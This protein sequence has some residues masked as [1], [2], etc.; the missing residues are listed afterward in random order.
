[1]RS[2]KIHL[3]VLFTLALTSASPCFS[4]TMSNTSTVI[5]LTSTCINDHLS[6]GTYTL[7]LYYIDPDNGPIHQTASVSVVVVHSTTVTVTLPSPTLPTPATTGY[8]SLPDADFGSL[9]F[10]GAGGGLMGFYHEPPD[11][12]LTFNCTPLGIT[13]NLRGQLPQPI[14]KSFGFDLMMLLK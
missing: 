4:Q 13:G 8:W 3:L 10:T 2:L 12:D 9:T 7:A 6:T 5:T 1:M 14:L 11:G